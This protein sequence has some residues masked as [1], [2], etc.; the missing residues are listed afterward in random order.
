[1]FVV[2]VYRKKLFSWVGHSTPTC[3]SLNSWLWFW[4]LQVPCMWR[5]T[6]VPETIFKRFIRLKQT[7]RT[8][9]T[10]QTHSDEL[11]NWARRRTFHE[12]NSLSLL[13]L[14]KRSTFRLGLNH[15]EEWVDI[16]S[17]SWKKMK[18]QSIESRED[19]NPVF[20]IY[21]LY[22]TTTLK[23]QWVQSVPTADRHFIVL[24][25]SFK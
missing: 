12:R 15:C 19:L 3:S 10:I 1:M 2:H 20:Y 11:N 4:R 18:D 17:N 9:W 7:V 22:L 23:K 14:M 21:L 5:S 16:I 13:C 6:F 8:G 25:W 24:L